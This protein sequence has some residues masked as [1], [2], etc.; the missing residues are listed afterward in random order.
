MGVD[1]FC[2]YRR[3]GVPCT[4]LYFSVIGWIH[5]PLSGKCKY[6]YLLNILTVVLWIAP[7]WLN[8]FYLHPLFQQKIPTK[9]QNYTGK[10]FK[11]CSETTRERRFAD[12]E[13]SQLFRFY[14][15]LSLNDFSIYN[16]HYSLFC[17]SVPYGHADSF[18]KVCS[19]NTVALGAEFA[20]KMPSVF[21]ELYKRR[22]GQSDTLWGQLF[23]SLVF[24]FQQLKSQGTKSIDI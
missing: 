4:A 7:S 18:S 20:G 24:T 13:G 9:M 1:P 12:K 22:Y 16:R 21:V 17:C 5:C 15:R 8:Q 3:Q 6:I 2:K 23:L 11:E 19:H 14:L 10:W